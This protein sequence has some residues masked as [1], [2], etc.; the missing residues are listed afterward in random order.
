MK[1][2]FK[3]ITLLLTGVILLNAAVFADDWMPTVYSNTP[4][5][6]ADAETK[7][8]I[9]KNGTYLSGSDDFAF[10]YLAG[11][12]ESG[13][14]L[15]AG[16]EKSDRRTVIAIVYKD[17]ASY[18]IIS[19]FNGSCDTKWGNGQF[20]YSVLSVNPPA[21]LF[22][23]N[24]WN[25]N[26]V[27]ITWDGTG[28][29]INSIDSTNNYCEDNTKYCNYF[30]KYMSFQY[31][32]CYLQGQKVAN[33][34]EGYRV[35]YSKESYIGQEIYSSECHHLLTFYGRDTEKD[36]YVY[37]TTFITDDSLRL[38]TSNSKNAGVVKLLSKDTLVRV[39]N[40]D[41]KIT[42]M[43]GKD[44]FW[45]LVETPELYVGWVWSAYLNGF[46]YDFK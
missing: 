43:E 22:N 36:C 15:K 28:F 7:N 10:Y 35:R 14:T 11:V 18:F 5:K 6:K 37:F 20:N 45:V 33:E 32:Y 25:A 44:G 40:V 17:T 30:I 12:V 24:E 38:R 29:I 34:G 19:L 26:K 31:K 46:D 23:F 27:A 39:L 13:N 16:D 21:I 42:Q 2:Y 8:F 1:S 9:V 41:P 4:M 3:R